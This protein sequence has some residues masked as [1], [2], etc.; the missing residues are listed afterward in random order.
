MVDWEKLPCKL[1]ESNLQQ[2]D[3]IFNKLHRIGCTVVKAKDPKVA[4]IT[5]TGDK[6]ETMAEME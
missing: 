1:K 3:D 2:A 6:I 4:K 5:F